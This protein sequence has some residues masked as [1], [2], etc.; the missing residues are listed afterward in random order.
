MKNMAGFD[1][2]LRTF[3]VAP[4]LIVL[5]FVVGAGSVL[6]I[7]FFVLAAVMVATS[8]VSFCPLYRLIGVSTCKT[9]RRGGMAA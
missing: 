9:G 4:I 2:L 1:R 8:L 7:I 6:G 5:A 3:L